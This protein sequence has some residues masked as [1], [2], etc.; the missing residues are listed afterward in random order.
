MIAR[1]LVTSLVLAAL[2]G[3]VVLAGTSAG[4]KSVSGGQA[5]TLVSLRHETVGAVTRIQVESSAPPLYTVFRPTERLIIVDLPGC[6]GSQLAPEYAV[7]SPLVGSVTVKQS[8]VAGVSRRSATRLE[9]ALAADAH[10][11]SSIAGNT[12]TLEV[13][14]EQKASAA[15]KPADVKR[16]SQ[17]NPAQGTESAPGVYVLPTPVTGG[18]S[19]AAAK[20]VASEPT[21]DTAPARPSSLRAATTIRDVRSEASAGGVRIVVDADGTVQYK[22]FMLADPWRVVIDISGVRSAIGNRVTSVGSAGIDRLRVGQPSGNTVRIVLDAKS[23]VNY[24][25]VRDGAQLVITVGNPGTSRESDSSKPQT[26]PAEKQPAKPV[27]GQTQKSEV[28]VAG[29]RIENKDQD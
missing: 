5:F 15:L 19:P 2:M 11:R 16:A 7:N 1:R 6:E 29:E 10:D 25:V 14:P 21:A 9:V 17:S 20:P 22:D 26:S 13:S 3:N 28:K 23:K 18:K 4:R 27:V 8:T 24:Q 12:F